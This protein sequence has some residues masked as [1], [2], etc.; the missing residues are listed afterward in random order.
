M[1][2]LAAAILLLLYVSKLG[3]SYNLRATK[4][5]LFKHT[6]PRVLTNVLSWKTMKIVTGIH[7]PLKGPHVP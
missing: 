7:S 4:F 3:L 2:V 1:K 5:A 6:V